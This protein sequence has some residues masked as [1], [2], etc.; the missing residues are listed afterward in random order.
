MSYPRLAAV[1]LAV[2][3]VSGAASAGTGPRPAAGSPTVFAV[4]GRGW[5]HGVGMSQWGAYGMAR[6][7][8]AYGAILAHYYRGTTLGRAPVARVRVLLA[9]GRKSVVIGSTAPFTV[10]DALGETHELTARRVTFGPGL[11][12]AVDGTPA[13]PLAGPLVF[14]PTSAPLEVGGKR[15]R[16]T[17]EV[18]V[19]EGRVRV[20]NGVRLEQYLWGVV[21]DEV[22]DEWPAEALKA[23]AVVA[24]SYALAVRRRTGPFDLYADV[25]SQVYGGI[26]SEERTTTAAVNATA[27]EV[28]LH[29]GKVA[30]TFFF[31]T[32]GG[33]TA[34][35]E[36]IWG[37]RPTPY[38]VSVP[39]PHDSAS[40]HHRWGPIVVPA[41]RMA[42]VIGA[43]A[44]ILDVRTTRNRSGRAAQVVGVTAQ[45]EIGV[46][47]ASL[48]EKLGLRSTWF[49]LGM[50]RLDRPAKAGHL[51]R[52]RAPHRAGARPLG[53]DARGAAARRLVDARPRCAARL[54][55]GAER[56][57]AGAGAE[58]VP[59]RGRVG[60]DACG[61]AGRCPRGAARRGGTP[62]AQ[63]HR[64]PGGARASRSGSSGARQPAAGAAWPRPCSARAA[65]S[66]RR[67]PSRPAPTARASRSAA[68]SRPGCQRRSSWRRRDAPPRRCR[69]PGGGRRPGRA[70]A[71]RAAR[72]RR[73]PRRLAARAREPRRR[74]AGRPGRAPG[75]RAAHAHRRLRVP[76]ARSSVSEAWPGWSGPR[77]R[78][79]S[80]VP[81]DPLAARQWYLA[82]TRA[83]EHWSVPPPLPPVRIA[84]VDSGIDGSHPDLA[85]RILAARSFVG[86]KPTDQHGHGTF[87]A[88]IAAAALNNGEGIAGD[89]VQRRAARGQ[90]REARTA[91]CR[92]TRSRSAIRWATDRGARV[93]NLS[94]GGLRD[95][96]VTARDTY[97]NLEAAAVRYAQQRGALVVAAV[98]NATEAPRQPWPYANYP[99]ALPHVVGVSALARDGAVPLFST[100]DRVHN[101]VAAPG[102]DI[103]STLP[104][105]LTA[106]RRTCVN[107]GY[108]DCGPEEYRHARG[109]SF[110]APQV[111]A[112]AALVMASQPLLDASQVAAVL[113]RSATDATT[114]SG[115]DV[116]DDGRDAASGWGRLDVAAALSTARAGR[117]VS[118]DGF[119]P[120]DDAGG[121]AWTLWGRRGRSI[122]ATLDYWDDQSDVYR[123]RLRQGE[124]LRATLRGPRGATL[125]LWRPGTERVDA[126][127]LF[128]HRFRAAQSVRRG[129]AARLT[130][131]ARKRYGGWYFLQ[132]KL[133]EPGAGRYS[134]GFT[135]RP[136]PAQRAT[137]R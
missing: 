113:T 97:S 32:S 133:T 103:F 106:E 60:A 105:A 68:A 66:R 119:E 80:F 83:F 11:K 43:G 49:T 4:S 110:A 50:L 63:R 99:A 31:S 130:Y 34:N 61:P 123:V 132:V 8:S 25:R 126:L 121:A 101:D 85:E 114:A 23:Q 127:T 79:V 87:V 16:G 70:G 59:A 42:Q 6:R 116:C 14:S 2:A 74:A 124:R 111:S 24:R 45:A 64:A 112:A 92:S 118:P 120:N 22:P 5:G 9:D 44:T 91:P 95:P 81:T 17:F 102:Q 54:R 15:Y 67:S 28:L 40:P 94:L 88:G 33:R 39:D 18:S 30:T 125:V 26:A 36:D 65:S 19:A 89:R 41:A 108:S 135:K 58:R 51:R 27:G 38:L 86:G 20:V 90:G 82:Q 73:P 12:I 53:R 117:L 57:R 128:A 115:C 1:V 78:R 62:G 100:R 52:A 107:Q 21:P 72:G 29:A 71:G 96:V 13:R 56:E 131:R 84:I 134:L 35:V 75:R 76:C 37:G 77:V 46:T 98:G 136:V 93:I 137:A 7:G 48:R 129:A 10:R 55:R 122:S 69:A 109:T 47:A 104:R 3:A